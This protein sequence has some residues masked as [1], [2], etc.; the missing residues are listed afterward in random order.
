M[1]KFANL[2]VFLALL[3]A[4]A[5]CGGGGGGDTTCNQGQS[6]TS[7]TLCRSGAISCSSGAPVCVDSGNAPDGSPSGLA[8][9]PAVPTALLIPDASA[10][11]YTMSPLT[12]DADQ[13]FAVAGVPTGSYF[14]E[15]N[16]TTTPL[17]RC[18]QELKLVPMQI[19]NLFELTANAPDLAYVTSTRPD[20][21]VPQTP[22]TVTFDISNLDPWV[23]GDSIFASSSQAQSTQQI[24]PSPLPGETSVAAMFTWIGEL[25]DA[26]KGDTVYVYH[27]H[28]TSIG[29]GPTAGFFT[30]AT[31]S[32]KLTNLTVSTT[33]PNS[34]TV[35]LQS[36]PQTGAFATAIRNSQAA[37][38]AADIN[39][40]AT[41]SDFA[42]IVAATPH[43]LSFPDMPLMDFTNVFSLHG[44]SNADVDYGT[45]QYGQFFDA[46]WKEELRVIW[47]YNVS[48]TNSGELSAVFT[49]NLPMP[50]PGGA[51]APVIGPPKSP[52]INGADAF[53]LHTGVGSQ[54]TISWSVPSF[55]TATS[56]VLDVIAADPCA[57]VGEIAGFS[58]VIRSG[59]S[60]KVP[61]GI[62]KPGVGY[63]VTITARQASWDTAD[64]GPFRTGT[65]RHSAQCVPA[66]FIP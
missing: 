12:L 32:L 61:P 66:D 47:T 29:T 52:R 2:T 19:L 33:A 27:R 26:S 4:V 17:V 43:S 31:K 57:L 8:D 54:P 25:P 16:A 28:L 56:Y 18:G 41:L 1:T 13:S 11:G 63:Q 15:L 7:S 14:L 24:L 3:F 36:T 45:I 62:L 46:V 37:S 38:L 55:G 59:T 5:A 20:A 21:I 53:A 23:R 9:P 30:S 48:P 51:I 58:A 22:P 35:A 40:T 6:C 10:A 42:V 39:P 50:P 64:A 49:S 44:T 34:A 60:F 65:T